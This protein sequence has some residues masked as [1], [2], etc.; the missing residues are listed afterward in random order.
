MELSDEVKAALDEKVF[1]HVATVN[2]DGSPHVSAMWV[3][4]EGDTVLLSTATGRV[5]TR[6]IEADRRVAL[7]FTPPDKPY[8]NIVMQ[9]RVTSIAEDGTWLIDALSDKYLNRP[10]YNGPE[11]EV[12]VNYEVTI[13]AIGRWG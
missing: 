3:G 4:R 12:R 9:G 11:G 7:S 13:D 5:K 2:P 6:N 8:T 10:D 1:V